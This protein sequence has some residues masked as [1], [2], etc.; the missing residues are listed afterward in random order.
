MSAVGDQILTHLSQ[1][2]TRSPLPSTP[3]NL[4]FSTALPEAPTETATLLAQLQTLLQ[5]TMNPAHPGYLG[6]MDPMASTVSLVGDW[7]AAA[8]NNNM[9]SVEMSPVFSQ[10]EPLLLQDLAQRFGLGPGAG[11]L[12]V[13]G[14]SLANL[15]AIAV[16][17]NVKL[18]VKT[19]GLAGLSRPPVMLASELAHTSLRKAAMVLG[20]GTDGLIAVATDDR[21]R[22]DPVALEEAIQGA[23]AAG[24]QPFAVVA[25]A[26]TTVTGSIDP[27]PAV[28]DVA[29]RYNL[30]FHVDAAYGGALIFSPQQR[31]RLKGIDQADSITFNPQKWLYVTKTCASV[32]FRQFDHLYQ[33]FQ[34]AAPYMNT[35]ADWVNLGE[36]TVQGTRHVDVLKLWLTLQH[37]GRRGCGALV[38]A[39][40]DL[41]AQFVQAIHDRPYLTLANPPEMNVICFRGC[42]NWVPRDRWDD[43]NQA[44]QR[45]LLE[46]GSCFLSLPQ[47]RQARWLKA[48]LLNPFTESTTLDGLFTALDAFVARGSTWH[49]IAPGWDG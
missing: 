29:R 35:E 16:A 28:A 31:D 15:Q 46:Q 3:A 36:L 11:G 20:L 12:L 49:P 17:R 9:L 48:V 6:H 39:S 43:W 14:G 25:T 44:L 47:Y 4:D 18:A 24:Q 10:L 30:W 42:P 23:I 37:F 8:L 13:S 32:L 22:L 2:A 40:Y 34:I 41:T 45:H 7:I 38:D 1:A 26:G 21:N 5:H 27:L 19:Q 33:G